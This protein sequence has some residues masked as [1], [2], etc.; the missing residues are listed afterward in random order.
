MDLTNLPSPEEIVK[1]LLASQFGRNALIV[2]IVALVLWLKS[3]FDFG[4]TGIDLGLR[5]GRALREVHQWATNMRPVAV[6]Q[7][8]IVTALL[9]ALQLAWLWGAYRVA[10]DLSYLFLGV[11]V[12]PN[13]WLGPADGSGPQWNDMINYTSSDWIASGYA[14]ICTFG[15]GAHYLAAFRP[16]R[17]GWADVALFA[18]V[19]PIVLCS[20]GAIGWCIFQLLRAAA[21]SGSVDAPDVRW[22][23]VAALLGPAYIIATNIALESTTT[24]HRMWSYR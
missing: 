21:L 22:P 19:V 23:I 24:I 6:V 18:A 2:S 14:L 11:W 3:W 4:K 12:G 8:S 1:A 13:G 16:V 17:E 5:T 15:L 7:S 20:I 9:V 10:N